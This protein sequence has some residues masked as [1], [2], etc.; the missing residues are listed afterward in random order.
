MLD[1][2]SDFIQRNQKMLLGVAVGVVAVIG[3][4]VASR[5]YIAS[6]NEEAQ[7]EMFHAIYRFEADSLKQALKG[8]GNRLGFADIADSYG[9]T[10][11]GKLAH[12]YIGAILLKQGKFAEAAE[13]LEQFSSDDIL[14]Q[15]RGYALTG[16][17]YSELKDY[18]KAAES[19]LKAANYKPNRFF[20][21]G[22]LMKLAGVQE[23]K[24]DY[25]GAANT[26]ERI[27]KNYYESQ[28]AA[29]A[30]KYLARAQGLATK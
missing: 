25:A 3:G 10:K 15:A 7:Q 17:A 30:R 6:Q 27:V 23:A 5:A 24:Q 16:D 12:F 18:D 26:Y 8:D 19:Y 29:E 21:P 9:Y 4:I 13:N 11:S 2:T 1:N 28:D 20:T 22:Y 14:V